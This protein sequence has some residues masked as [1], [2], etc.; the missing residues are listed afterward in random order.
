L[1]LPHCWADGSNLITYIGI[2]IRFVAALDRSSGF[3][4]RGVRPLSL[5]SCRIYTFFIVRSRLGSLLKQIQ[6]NAGTE[7]RNRMHTMI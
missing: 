5:I 3:T 1:M 6:Q 2:T 7:E 4:D